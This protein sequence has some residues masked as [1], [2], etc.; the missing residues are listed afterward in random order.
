M[1]NTDIH[2]RRARQADLP[3]ICAIEHEL[4]PDPWD[5]SAFRD[6]LYLYPGLFFVA[7]NG[8]GIIASSPPGWRTPGGTRSTATS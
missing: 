5:E 6:A 2:I 8:N 1:Q 7:E 3:G 4:F